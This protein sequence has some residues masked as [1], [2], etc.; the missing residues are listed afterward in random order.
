MS[1]DWSYEQ[2]ID[3][4]LCLV[5]MLV[6]ADNKNDWRELESYEFWKKNRHYLSVKNDVLMLKN[7]QEELVIVVPKHLT[8]KICELYH[9]SVTGGHLG[10]DKTCDAISKRFYWPRMKSFI[11][12]FCSTCDTCQKQK[13]KNFS[14]TAPLVSI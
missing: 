5:K 1:L 6:K 4:E 13:P 9:N 14:G 10:F 11:F 8:H 2:S 3:K 7:H 12:D